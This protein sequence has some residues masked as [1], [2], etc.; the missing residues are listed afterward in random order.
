MEI[1]W[2]DAYGG[3]TQMFIDDIKRHKPFLVRS[4]GYVF[5]EDKNKI[6]LGFCLYSNEDVKHWQVIPKKY[7]R[8]KKILK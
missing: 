3:N 4:V 8:S 6:C 5:F 7:I 1:I 2:E